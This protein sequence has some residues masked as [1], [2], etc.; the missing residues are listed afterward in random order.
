MSI[1]CLNASYKE[2]E[3]VKSLGAKWCDEL[4]TWYIDDRYVNPINFTKWIP[5]VEDKEFKSFCEIK[6]DSSEPNHV[7]VMKI[8][9]AE[10][11]SSYGYYFIKKENVWQKNYYLN[12]KYWDSRYPDVYDNKILQLI[13]NLKKDAVMEQEMIDKFIE[14]Y[15]EKIKLIPPAS[16]ALKKLEKDSKIEYVNLS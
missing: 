10:N 5:I 1:F 15:L 12:F 2:K 7:I 8:Q 9:S 13:K 3:L 4:K 14:I 6:L 16:F 11:L